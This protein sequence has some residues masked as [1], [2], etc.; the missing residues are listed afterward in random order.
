MEV[1]VGAPGFGHQ[2]HSMN[3]P[4]MLVLGVLMTGMASVDW[5]NHFVHLVV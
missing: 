1:H 2:G 3:G 5:L 4:I